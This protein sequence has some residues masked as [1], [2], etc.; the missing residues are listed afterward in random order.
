MRGDRVLMDVDFKRRRG[1]AGIRLGPVV[2]P[3]FLDQLRKDVELLKVQ[4]LRHRLSLPPVTQ[5][6]LTFCAWSGAGQRFHG[7]FSAGRHSKDEL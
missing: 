5:C 7:L 2:G 4:C 6:S 3:A 1:E